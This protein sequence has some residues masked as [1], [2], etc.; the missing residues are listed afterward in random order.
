M[1]S[2]RMV[3]IGD[4]YRETGVLKNESLGLAFDNTYAWVCRFDQ[5]GKIVEV[6]AYL[7][8]ELVKRA[9]EENE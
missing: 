3:C 6:R 1:L 9:I 8:S 7:D 4:R 2:V 5:P